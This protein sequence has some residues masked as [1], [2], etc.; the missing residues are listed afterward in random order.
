MICPDV[1]RWKDMRNSAA[2]TRPAT[3]SLCGAAVSRQGA[4]QLTQ[5]E[6]GS[7]HQKLFSPKASLHSLWQKNIKKKTVL[8]HL[9]DGNGCHGFRSVWGALDQCQ[10]GGGEALA[11]D[12]HR[13]E[14]SGNSVV[15]LIMAMVVIMMMMRVVKKRERRYNTSNLDNDY[16]DNLDAFRLDLDICSPYR[17]WS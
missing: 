12:L 7:R 1:I 8:I 14:N 4:P 17:I 6:L 2:A 16:G 15:M 9:R 3:S 5:N 10:L 13:F 11:S